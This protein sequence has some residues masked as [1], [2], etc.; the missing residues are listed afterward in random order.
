MAKK[1]SKRR[2]LKLLLIAALLYV[3]TFLVWSRVRTFR[4]SVDQDRFWS[5]FPPPGGLSTVNPTRWSQ[6]KRNERIAGTVFWPCVLLDEKFTKRRYWPAH[7][8][9]P[10]R[11]VI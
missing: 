5:F 6:W 10:P 11:V 1:S 2:W 4:L 7:F 8:A 9:D 3:A